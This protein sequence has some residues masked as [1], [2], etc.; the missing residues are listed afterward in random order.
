M[1]SDRR[2]KPHR[3]AGVGARQRHEVPHRRVRRDLAPAHLLLDFPRQLA[4]EREPPAHPARAPVEALPELLH[5][6]PEA[7]AQLGEQ[8]P[9]LERAGAVP[10]PHEPLEEQR[11]RLAEVPDHGPDRVAPEP[12][13]CPHALVAVDEHVAAAFTYRHHD[14][15]LLAGLGERREKPCLARGAARP[16][17]LVPQVDLVELEIH[18]AQAPSVSAETMAEPGSG[19]ASRTGGVAEFRL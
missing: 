9:L 12:L 15:H 17:R 18:R 14:R 10:V 16:Q 5:R 6:H 4:H 8:P 7:V 1:R 13:E 3:L 2:G 11:L 19:L